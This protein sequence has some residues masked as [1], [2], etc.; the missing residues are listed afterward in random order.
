MNWVV[1]TRINGRRACAAT[2]TDWSYNPYRSDV[3]RF[4]TKTEAIVFL[5][6]N[7]DAAGMA[8]AVISYIPQYPE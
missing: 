4:A 8:D 3:L 2:M 7:R 5:S 1:E 6:E